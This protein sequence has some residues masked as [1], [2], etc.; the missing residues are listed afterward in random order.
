M[1]YPLISEYIESIKSAE[2]NFEEHIDDFSFVSILLSLKAISINPTLL[3]EYGA[4]DRLIFS[5]KDYRSLSECEKIAKLLALNNLDIN[6]L[7]GLLLL[8]YTEG[9][10]SNV[11]FKL[12][13]VTKP[14]RKISHLSKV[15]KKK[16]TIVQNKEKSRFQRTVEAELYFSFAVSYAKG[17][18]I[19]QD[20]T[21]ALEYINKAEEKGDTN[22]KEKCIQARTYILAKMADGNH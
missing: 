6:R 2:D 19:Q 3:E 7:L 21:Q 11:S 22:M 4:T 10:L 14:Q 20:Y 5:E 17:M 16:D 1:N 12:L 13:Y 18:G 8:A 9:N 15:E